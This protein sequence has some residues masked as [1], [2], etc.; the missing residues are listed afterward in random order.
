[1]KGYKKGAYMTI[2]LSFG[3]IFGASQ[4]NIPLGLLLGLAIGAGLEAQ[5]MKKD[6]GDKQ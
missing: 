5:Q 2:G 3:I 1:M 6:K 4:Q